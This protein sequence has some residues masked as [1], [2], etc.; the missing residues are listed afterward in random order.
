MNVG[1]VILEE[2][3]EVTE[4]GRKQ[5]ILWFKGRFKDLD[6]TVTEKKGDIGG[7]ERITGCCVWKKLKKEK[8]EQK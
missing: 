8:E 6:F 1:K 7:Y 4:E 2:V 3:R 5:I